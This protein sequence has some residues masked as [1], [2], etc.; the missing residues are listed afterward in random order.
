[1]W[2]LAIVAAASA[3]GNF[4]SAKGAAKANQQTAESVEGQMEFQERMS[5]TAVQRRVA[6]LKAAGINPLLA[7]D[8]AASTPAGASMV[9]Q[10]TAAPW[11]NLGN[12]MSSA[13]SAW[14]ET[15]SMSRH[16]EL[17]KADVE[18]AKILA[19]LYHMSYGKFL[20][21]AKETF[22][23]LSGAISALSTAGGFMGGS[24]RMASSPSLNV[25]PSYYRG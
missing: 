8:L 20:I 9:Y 19:K 13:Y 18:K 6:D 7:G 4:F 23:S 1:M 22:G 3:V 24:A 11:Q 17:T 10:N 2:P 14:N 21:Y 15:R 16:L 25:S 5:N 12:Q